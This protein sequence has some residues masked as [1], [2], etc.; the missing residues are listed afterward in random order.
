MGVVCCGLPGREGGRGGGREGGEGEREREGGREG[1]GR[2][3][4]GV[5]EGHVKVICCS[6]FTVAAGSCAAVVSSSFN[7]HW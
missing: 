3:R 5:T 4:E 2:E 6:Y 1:G 7:F